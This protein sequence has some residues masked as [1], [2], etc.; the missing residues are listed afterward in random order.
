MRAFLAATLVLVVTAC[1]AGAPDNAEPG[2][3][4]EPRPRCTYRW[5]IPPAHRW[6][7][8]GWL[9][10]LP[11]RD[12]PGAFLVYWPREHLAEHIPGYQIEVV[13]IKADVLSRVYVIP[14]TEFYRHETHWL[15]PTMTEMFT[16]SGEIYGNWIVEPN[17]TPP[18]GYRIWDPLQT[19]PIQNR[20]SG[21][22]RWISRVDPRGYDGRPPQERP[23][24]E[25]WL[26]AGCLWTGGFIPNT[27]PHDQCTFE[28]RVAR[29]ISTQYSLSG[30]NIAL[31]EQVTAHMAEMLKSWAR[32]PVDDPLCFDGPFD[33]FPL[34]FDED[35]G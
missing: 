2:A 34:P 23:R 4:P 9:D 24:R 18:G 33:G 16:R 6:Q 8:S 11:G 35:G 28:A 20:P 10:Q 3:E 27:Q 25:E 15:T 21:S 14:H 29:D 7:L 19:N 26:I 22:T 12:R 17:P 30:P 1:G 32:K 5:R 13:R 31:H